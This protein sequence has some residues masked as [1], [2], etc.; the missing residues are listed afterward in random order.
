MKELTPQQRLEALLAEILCNQVAMMRHE[1]YLSYK[2][3]IIDSRKIM[4]ELGV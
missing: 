2:H 1:D 3:R 4:E